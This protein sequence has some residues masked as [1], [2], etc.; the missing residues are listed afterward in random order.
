MN[1][2]HLRKTLSE[3]SLCKSEKA[4]L[5]EGVH[6]VYKKRASKGGDVLWHT[7]IKGQKELAPGF[8]LHMSLKVF[9]NKK[10]MDLN[11][12]KQKVKELNIQ[13]PKPKDLTFKTTIFTSERDGKKYYM[14]LMDG[15]DKAYSRFYE[16]FKHTGTVYKKFMPHIT[17]DK[18]LY[19]RINEEGLKP[20][21]VSFSNLTIEAGAG[22]TIYT[23]DK[24][25]DLDKAEPLLKPWS[26]Q[27][28]AAWGHSP[29]GKEALGGEAAVK[30]WDRATKGK[31]LPKHVAKTEE[32]EKGAVKNALTAGMMA[33]ALA[34]A[35]PSEAKAPLHEP[36]HPTTSASTNSGGY[37]RDKMLNAISQVESSGGKNVH[38]KPTSV[39]TAYGRFAEMPDVIHD[40]I[41]L[42]PDLKRQHGKALRLQGDNLN[43]YMQDNKGLED[44]C[45][46]NI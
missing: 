45:S 35:A 40:T 29:E 13:T 18:G 38:H 22:N 20:E 8:P 46:I 15:V 25:E 10:D 32:L 41:R 44:Y 28:Q 31:H 33:G 6:D 9:E 24:N 21:E 4:K 36:L 12:I 2:K 19:D 23:F 16:D 34:S 5:G 11:E 43:R 37:S 17:I 30:E 26:S 39:G 27:A 14:L 7:T 42:N 1:L 3:N